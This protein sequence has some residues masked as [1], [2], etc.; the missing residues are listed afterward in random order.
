MYN[1]AVDTRLYMKTITDLNKSLS[2]RVLI[3]IW[4]NPSDLITVRR[5]KIIIP[6]K[7]I[8]EQQAPKYQSKRQSLHM[9]YAQEHE[10][11]L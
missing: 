5:K 1:E 8:L 11:P 7:Q 6:E 4:K 3:H 9:H 2:I 10:D